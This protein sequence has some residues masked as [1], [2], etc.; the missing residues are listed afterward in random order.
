MKKMTRE[1]LAAMPHETLNRMAVE[2]KISWSEW[3]DAQPESYGGYD[4][5]LKTNGYT[6][7]DNAA[8][9]Y[10]RKC[11]QELMDGE[12]SAGMADGTY[13]IEELREKVIRTLK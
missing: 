3:I 7:S 8:L 13:T 4:S 6:R 10:I 12:M 2:G 11:E 9:M 1:E 5:W